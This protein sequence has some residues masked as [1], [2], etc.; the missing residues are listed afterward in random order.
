MLIS[1]SWVQILAFAPI[2]D[3][4]KHIDEP[5]RPMEHENGCARMG[6]SHLFATDGSLF[7]TFWSSRLGSQSR[8]GSM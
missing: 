6:K 5:G 8:V 7:R 4:F 1:L 3:P 2:A